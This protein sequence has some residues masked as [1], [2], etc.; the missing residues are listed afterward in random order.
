MQI[1]FLLRADRTA[2][3]SAEAARVAADAAKAS[4]DTL[5]QVERAYMLFDSKASLGGAQNIRP[6]INQP[7]QFR[8]YGK[9]PALCGP[10][11][12]RFYFCEPEPEPHP[13]LSHTEP[14]S[15]VNAGEPMQLEHRPLEATEAQFERARRTGGG[16]FLV[17]KLVY[18]DIFG[19]K[20]ETGVCFMWDEGASAF[21][22]FNGEH[23]LNYHT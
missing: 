12:A 1:G 11:Y 15:S 7:V 8:N 9:T 6:G 16:L 20:H 10:L 23:R 3:I 14:I 13:T 5:P 4:A 2:R 18:S 21:F 19:A 17:A 22:L